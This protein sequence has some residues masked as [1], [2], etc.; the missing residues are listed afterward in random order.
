VNVPT[1]VANAAR[2]AVRLVAWRSLR[3]LLNEPRSPRRSPLPS[4]S[5]GPL[6]SR[7]PSRPIGTA[8]TTLNVV[9]GC[10]RT[11]R[12]RLLH[13]VRRVASAADVRSVAATLAIAGV[14]V[15]AGTKTVQPW[16]SSWSSAPI[17]GAWCTPLVA[18]C[19]AMVAIWSAIRSS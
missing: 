9:S 18:C 1:V 6:L 13:P 3:S 11:V 7:R 19:S 15:V 14:V 12:L 4:L 10:A 17:N 8:W 5:E 16:R 2:V